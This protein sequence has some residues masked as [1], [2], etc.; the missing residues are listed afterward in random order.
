MRNARFALA[1]LALAAAVG[2]A[3]QS[4]DKPAKPLPLK[5]K[6]STFPLGI[7]TDFL[8]EAGKKTVVRI[9]ADRAGAVPRGLDARDQGLPRRA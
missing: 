3:A 8:G 5:T 7:G 6:A 2:L 4:Q 1:L 9:P